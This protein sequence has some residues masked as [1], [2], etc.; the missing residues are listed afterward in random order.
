MIEKERGLIQV[1]LK[2]MNKMSKISREHFFIAD[3]LTPTQSLYANGIVAI[4]NI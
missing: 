3:P 2:V 4:Q 1:Q